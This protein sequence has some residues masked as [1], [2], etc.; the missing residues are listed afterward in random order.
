MFSWSFFCY[1]D[2]LKEAIMI[3]EPLFD[4][5]FFNILAPILLKF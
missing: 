3:L 1:L 4:T 5:T 2:L